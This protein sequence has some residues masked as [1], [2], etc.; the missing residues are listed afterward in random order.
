MVTNTFTRMT[1][2]MVLAAL[3]AT[4]LGACAEATPQISG[5]YPDVSLAATKSSAQLL[6]NEV[7]NRLPADT[8]DEI[9]STED[10]SIPC[11]SAEDD[12]DGL[13]RAWNSTVSVTILKDGSIDVSA[14][15]TDLAASFEEQG[16]ALESLGDDTSVVTKLLEK[17][18]SPTDIEITG[19]APSSDT[20]SDDSGE[21]GTVLIR[22]HGPCVRTA[23]T[24]SDEVTAL[25]K[26]TAE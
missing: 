6:R 25:E 16:W 22:V 1:A 13:V 19:F 12:P 11:L 21:Q 10:A 9:V 18:G 17:E 3:V 20:E 8:I 5:D 26:N 2:A 23:G 14:V 7:A 24:E 4:G 15:V